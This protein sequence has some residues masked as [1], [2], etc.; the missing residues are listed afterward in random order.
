MAKLPENTDAA[1]QAYFKFLRTERRVKERSLRSYKDNLHGCF[2]RLEAVG[3]D[4]LPTK[5]DKNAVHSLLDAF[6]RDNL[7][8]KTRKNYIAALNGYLSYYD[9]NT[10]SRMGIRW[11]HDTRPNVKWLTTEQA[12]KLSSHRFD[13]PIV[14]L[15]I[16]CELCLGM[17]RIEVLR[18][19]MD[20]FSPDRVRIDGKG[21]VTDKIRYMPL[22]KRTWQILNEYLEWRQEQID[23]VHARRPSTI[24]PDDL[25]L[26]RRFYTIGSFE[27]VKAQ[28]L[29]NYLRTAGKEAIG[30][31]DLS[32]HTLRRMFG[33]VMWMDGIK[34]ETIADMLGHETLEQCVDY[35]GVNIS[36]MQ[37]A[38]SQFSL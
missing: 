16:H 29:N 4:T 5:I 36:D 20:S 7:T 17:R 12:H 18:L 24:I 1:I 33:R 13:K 19:T 10:I 31:E 38:M 27:S 23:I 25:M 30:L 11:P 3:H 9:N 21:K 6:E 15:L 37:S 2:I 22:H 8:V 14:N 28:A 35:I 26:W 34:I 32:H